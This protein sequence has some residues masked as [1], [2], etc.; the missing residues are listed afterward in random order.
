MQ[1][2]KVTVGLPV[3]N[4]EKYL[5]NAIDRILRQDYKDFDLVICDNASTD[6]TQEICQAY[7]AKDPRIRYFRNETN[8]GL[9]ANHNR[10]FELSRGEFFKWAAHDD[11]FPPTM[12]GRLVREFQQAPPSVALIYS[13]CEYVDEFGHVEGVD[14]DHVDKDSSWPHRR[15][16]HLLRHIHM[17]NCPYGL[18]RS[19][20]LR[21]SRLYGLFPGSD[22]VLFAEL[23]MLGVF[24]EIPEPLLR[25]RRHPGRTFTANKEL[26]AL[27]ELFTPG[28]GDRFL[29]I[30]MWTHINLELIRSAVLV[31]PRLRDKLLCT[32]VAVVKPQWESFRA[33]G[34][35]QKQKLLRRF[36]AAKPVVETGRSGGL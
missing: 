26:K 19:A 35:R 20:M 21:K 7:A 23:A 36:S 11:D 4:G 5:H 29:P 17:Y 31:P 8:I 33:F 2:P 25:I 16:S 14:S 24:I 1:I 18:I 3:Y 28:R 30:G 6:K 34:G 9:A 22:H 10:T 13:Y 15:L 32:V 27:R 12:L